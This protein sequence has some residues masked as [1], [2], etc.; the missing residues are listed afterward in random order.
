[1]NIFR[2]NIFEKD[3]TDRYCCSVIA[4]NLVFIDFV[5]LCVCSYLGSTEGRDLVFIKCLKILWASKS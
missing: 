5:G 3:S 4:L 2:L 1:M